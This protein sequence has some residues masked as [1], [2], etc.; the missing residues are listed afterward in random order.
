MQNSIKFID[1]YH[2][3]EY[4]I[5]DYLIFDLIRKENFYPFW[6]MMEFSLMAIDLS[7]LEN[8][9]VLTNAIDFFLLGVEGL[10]IF[11]PI[12]NLLFCT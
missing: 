1:N 3:I 4:N 7:I 9:R 12:M 6:K 10:K 8:D 11:I 2:F 5:L